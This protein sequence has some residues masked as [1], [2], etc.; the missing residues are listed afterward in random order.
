[1]LSL[2][3]PLER[4]PQ[5][6]FYNPDR[7]VLASTGAQTLT[8]PVVQRNWGKDTYDIGWPPQF[9]FHS[10]IG[11]KGR[12]GDGANGNL[13]GDPIAGAFGAGGLGLSGIGEGGGGLGAE[14]R[15]R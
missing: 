1:M 10:G 4:A 2:L 5:D 7:K 9:G 14:H 13:W 8:W 3:D 15:T 11:P 6:R 12:A